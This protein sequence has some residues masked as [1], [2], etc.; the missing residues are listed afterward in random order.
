MFDRA[1]QGHEKALGAE[2]TSTL[3][4]VNSL[5]IV[6]WDQGK[7]AKAEKMYDRVLQG[8]EKA[9]GAEHPT[10]LKIVTISK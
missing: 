7:F 8:Y 10:T 6:Y 4:I 1:L 9:L 5:G 2:H 3:E